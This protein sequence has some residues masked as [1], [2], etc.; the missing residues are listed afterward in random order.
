MMSFFKAILSPSYWLTHQ[1]PVPEAWVN[2]LVALFGLFLVAGLVAGIASRRK[3]FLTPVRTLLRR[4][5][6]FGWTM[7]L[8]GYALLFF[9]VQQVAFFSARFLYLA[10]GIAT[11]VWLYKVLSYA[12]FSLPQRFQE[13]KEK[14][15]REK[16]LPKAGK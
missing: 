5:S 10:W 8:L 12:F 13:Q 3:A 1:H 2:A 15:A 9:S 4:I 7:G 6:A 11:L 14:A 16:Y